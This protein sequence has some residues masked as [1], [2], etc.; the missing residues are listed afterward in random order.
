MINFYLLQKTSLFDGVAQKDIEDILKNVDTGQETFHKGA[1][2]IR[3]GQVLRDI[4]VLTSGRARAVKNG[5][6]GEEVVV[7]SLVKGS[8]FAD[9]LSGSMNFESPVEVVAATDCTVLFISYNQ[10][11]CS[12]HPQAH[13]VLQNMIKTISL[14]YFAQN[15]HLEILMLKGVRRRLEF[16]LTAQ[17]QKNDS[18]DFYIDFDR[19]RLADYLGVDRSALSR[20]LSRMQNEG[21][22]EYKKN[23]FHIMWK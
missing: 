11:V 1:V 16:F 18:P 22:L 19:R 4:G 23:F 12:H 17:S 8:V 9:I 15:L 7:S 3:Q 14:K 13:R 5:L 6:D 2:I 10:L 21:L 20:E